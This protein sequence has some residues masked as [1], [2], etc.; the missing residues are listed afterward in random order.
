MGAGLYIIIV[1]LVFNIPT[2]TKHLKA[3]TKLM[4][5]IA[6]EQ[7]AEPEKIDEILSTAEESTYT[8]NTKE[9]DKAGA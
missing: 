7:G 8:R 6:K 3:Q 4:A 9:L 1:R 2:I 5:L